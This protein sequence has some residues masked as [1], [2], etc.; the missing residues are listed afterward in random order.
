MNND[1]IITLIFAIYQ[2][3]WQE[4]MD[5]GNFLENKKGYQVELT[6][7]RQLCEIPE[8]D[9]NEKNQNFNVEIGEQHCNSDGPNNS[10]NRQSPMTPGGTRPLNSARFRNKNAHVF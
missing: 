4:A 8:T 5:F 1:G 10:Y 2:E 3:A 9:E 6:L 7:I